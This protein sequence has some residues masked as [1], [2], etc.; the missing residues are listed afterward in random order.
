MNLSGNA[1]FSNRFAV[2][3]R[4]RRRQRLILVS[5]A[6]FA[7]VLLVLLVMSFGSGQATAAKFEDLAEDQSSNKV[8]ES[9]AQIYVPSRDLQAGEQLKAEDL[10]EVFWAKDTIPQDAIKEKSEVVGTFAS[11]ALQK[12]EPIKKSSISIDNN[13]SEVLNITPGMRAVTIE[14]NAKRGIEGWALPGTRVDV[15]LTY[16]A[17]GELTSKIVVE[18]TRV[19]SNGGDSGTGSGDRLGAR[20]PMTGS[21]TVTLETTPKD[22][23]KIE[24]AQQ[25]GTLTLHMRSLEDSKTS[26]VETFTENELEKDDKEPKSN[27]NKG[28][29]KSDCSRGKMKIGGKEY[30]VD[31]NGQIVKE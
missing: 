8:E 6:C 10:E 30:I 31:C 12:G 5:I 7:V 15:V 13:K 2:L 22:A 19:L 28:E 14:V 18:N 17:D 11:V 16:V 24:T 9:T 3:N 26:G 21:T 25:K 23:L 20:K 29:K 27:S 4:A 1:N